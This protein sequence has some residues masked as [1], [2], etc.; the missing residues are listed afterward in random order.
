MELRL[1]LGV[2]QGRFGNFSFVETVR[3]SS[4]DSFSLEV[5]VCGYFKRRKK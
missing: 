2:D 1:S 3:S 4:L 5:K